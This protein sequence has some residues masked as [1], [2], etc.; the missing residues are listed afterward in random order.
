MEN[1]AKE[2]GADKFLKWCF[3]HKLLYSLGLG[4]F[5]YLTI[6]ALEAP[7][8]GLYNGFKSNWWFIFFG[9]AS[10]YATPYVTAFFK[11][12]E[13]RKEEQR[14]LKEEKLRQEGRCPYCGRLI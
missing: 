7:R 13:E 2:D 12:I 14:K 3:T 1:N 8:V 9:I 10:V 6:T 5:F 4:S 11:K